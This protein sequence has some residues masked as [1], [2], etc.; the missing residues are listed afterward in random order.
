MFPHGS[1]CRHHDGDIAEELELNGQDF[2]GELGGHA[3]ALFG[4]MT[5]KAEHFVNPFSPH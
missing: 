3:K 1:K 4:K 5:V 2:H